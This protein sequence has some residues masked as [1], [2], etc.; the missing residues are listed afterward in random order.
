MNG[1]DL[2][3]PHFIT[4]VDRGTGRYEA[5]NAKASFAPKKAAM[6][7]MFGRVADTATIRRKEDRAF[8][9]VFV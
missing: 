7:S 9:V 6:E 8:G 2:A 3:S 4:R 1:F 5:S